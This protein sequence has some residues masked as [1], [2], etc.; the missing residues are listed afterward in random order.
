M[1]RSIA[2]ANAQAAVET[3]DREVDA[4]SVIINDREDAAAVANVSA[5]WH[6]AP[7]LWKQSPTS[8]R[9]STKY[10]RLMAGITSNSDLISD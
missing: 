4:V 5:N 9:H 7:N 3:E 8:M 10:H 6:L 1:S 2:T